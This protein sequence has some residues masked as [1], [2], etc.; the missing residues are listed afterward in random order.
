MHTHTSRQSMMFNYLLYLYLSL[1]NTLEVKK[2]IQQW[3]YK[4]LDM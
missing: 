2:E 3:H 4:D 1:N